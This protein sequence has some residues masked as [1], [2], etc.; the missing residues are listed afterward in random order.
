MKAIVFL[1]EHID[2]YIHSTMTSKYYSIFVQENRLKRREVILNNWT[3]LRDEWISQFHEYVDEI[4][5]WCV[6][7]Q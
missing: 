1:N 4:N 7:V 6:Y 3:D 5:V 2:I